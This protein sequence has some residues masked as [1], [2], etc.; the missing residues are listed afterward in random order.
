MDAHSIH[1]LEYS[2]VIERLVAHTSNGIGSGFARE[3]QPLAYPETVVRRLQ[4]TR[5]ARLLRDQ[6]GGIP[7]GG[8]HDVRG[9]LERARLETRLSPREL[10][11][12]MHTTGAA[13][14]LRSA[15]QSH[16]ENCPL[17][18][19]M[20]DGLPA[21]QPVEQ[22]IDDCISEAAEVRD[23]ASAELGRLR[24]Q[25]RVSSAR[26]NDRLQNILISE[27]GRGYLQEYVVTSREGR[28][29]VPVKA[30]YARAFGGIVHD[31]SQSGATLYVEPQQTVALGNELKQLTLDEAR[32]VDRILQDLSSLIGGC[33]Q[34]M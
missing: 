3:L 16:R 25:I 24:G 18:A 31:S 15:L 26:L 14:R 8:I 21:L 6:H 30:E 20:A 22:R 5:E 33:H 10:L 11:D 29:C 9:S 28:Y 1:V 27:R 23:S 19:E 17:L 32:E 4:E 2:E 13:R 7:L 12:V 34:E